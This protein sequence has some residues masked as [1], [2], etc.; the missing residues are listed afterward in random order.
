MPK[1]A[2]YLTTPIYYVNDRP[3]IGHCYTTGVADVAARFGRLLGDDVYFLTGTDEHADKVIAKAVEHNMTEQQWVD[4]CA[5]EFKKAFDLL[6]YSHDVFYRTSDP[7]HKKLAQQYI[8]QLLQQGDVYLG[9]YVGWYDVSQDEYLTDSVAEE[10]GFK[11]PVTGRPLE[12][13]TE[14]NYFFR[15]SG[16]EKALADHF[17]ANPDFVLPSE[18]RNEVLGRL[19]A[20]L[21]DVPVSRAI[22]PGESTWGVL[23]PNDANHRVYVWIEALCNYLTAVDTAEKNRYWPPACHF[24]AKDILWFHA[25]IWPAM[26]IALKRPLPK[27]VY[28]HAYWV[29][30]GVKMSKT[31]GNFVDIDV[32]RAYCDRFG[33]DAFRYYLVTQGPQNATDANFSHAK[34]VETFNA[35]LAN[36]IGN[37]ARRVGT[38]VDNS[39][40]G[41][42]P[43][44]K[45]VTKTID[46]YDWPA[47]TAAAA[48]NAAAKANAHDLVGATAEA[49][50]LVRA[51][52]GYINATK[53]FSIAKKID[54]DPALKDQLG[55]ILYHC[56]EAIRVATLI[57]S[58]TMP[59]KMAE[60]WQT[61]RCTP[62]AGVPLAKLADY[63]GPHALKP[64]QAVTKG[65]VLFMRA[66][67]AEAPPA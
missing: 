6:G 60:I 28:A 44:P 57:L 15:L 17:A 9:D 63:H 39:F 13:R 56:A 41:V 26:L 55:A 65:E 52:D 5:G 23:M 22:K 64:G 10:A 66:D 34:F 30:E 20:G 42:L 3:H 21:K 29:R 31:L 37:V 54:T 43:D 45:G 38:M 61:W 32:I 49:I 8:A 53:P 58:P 36:G 48:A 16:Y 11:S 59:A 33:R 62:A 24:M 4:Q 27:H 1:R 7:H 51:V 47:L 18:R 40:N 2:V 14:K 67:P 46:G 25:V 50:A 19:K 35:E 12:K